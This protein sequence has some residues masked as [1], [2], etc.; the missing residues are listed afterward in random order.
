MPA[1]PPPPPLLIGIA[2]GLAAAA[3]SAASYLV[4]RHHGSR[5]DGA[6]LRLLVPAHVLMGLACLPLVPALWPAAAPPARDWVP[7]LLQSAGCYLVGQ[8]CV[9]AA[10]RRMPA[11]RLAPLLGL[12]IAMLAVIVSC[13]PGEPLD[14]RQWAAVALAVVAALLM[15][16]GGDAS[17]GWTAVGGLAIV[18]VG[19][20]VYAISDLGI[21]GLIDALQR[22]AEPGVA[23]PGRLHAGVLAMAVTYVLCG[24]LALP[25]MSRAG[26]RD[27]RDWTAAAQYAA[28]WLGGMVA[29]YACFGTVGVVF[30][31]IL[32]STRGIMAVAAGVALA[33]AGW[34]D[35]EERVDRATLLRRLAAAALMTAAISLYVI[36]P[37]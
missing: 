17:A 36:D 25:F 21:I 5:T 10:L 35:L 31:N 1:T 20:L 3:A 26:L 9:Y 12:K 19:C 18:L 4:A 27:R 8:A 30:G 23:V 16:G 34:H 37:G 33:H 28:A 24:A 22:P 15:R 13:L 7:P 11:S 14:L 29:L 2:A 6:G 32:Q